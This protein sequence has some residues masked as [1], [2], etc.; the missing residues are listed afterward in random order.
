MTTTRRDSTMPGFVVEQL[1]RR[2][3][4]TGAGQDR[5]FI[6]AEDLAKVSGASIT[7][8]RVV[9]QTLAAVGHVRSQ[10]RPR[11][12]GKPGPPEREWR[13]IGPTDPQEAER[14]RRC[15]ELAHAAIRKGLEG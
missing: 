13:W 15:L 3:A 12:P 5:G 14:A 8:V 7:H 6:T 11:P 10:T 4:G 1:R 2:G 9:L